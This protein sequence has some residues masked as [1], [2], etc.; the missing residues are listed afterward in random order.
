ME[1]SNPD[2]K[3]TVTTNNKAKAFWRLMNGYKGIYFIA[4]VSVGFAALARTGL[5]FVLGT[6]VDELLPSDN[7]TSML[8]LV[9]LTLLG[10]ALMQGTFSYAGGR[11]AA[12]TSEGIAQRLRNYLLRSFTKTYI[13]LSR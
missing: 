11:L 2:L 10:L 12:K 6:Y 13:Y 1:P 5:Y 7:L 4:I 3:N 8:P 9:V